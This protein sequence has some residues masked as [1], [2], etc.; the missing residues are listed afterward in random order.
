MKNS[1]ILLA[2]GVGK[3]LGNKVPKQFVKFGNTSLIEYFLAHLSKSIFYNII[4]AVSDEN[5]KKYLNSLK[6]QFPQHNFVFALA[7]KSRQ[8]SSKNALK[9]LKKNNPTNVLIHDSARPIISN[10]LILK[11]IKSLEKNTAVI[12]FVYH[13]N[14]IKIKSQKNLVLRN[15]QILHIQ[16][17]QGFKFKDIL[18]AHYKT[19]LFNSKDDST[20]I[21]ENGKKIKYIKGEVSNL[22]IT[23]KDDI[24][25]F[26]KIKIKEY[27]SGIGYDIHK[28][29]FQSNKK[30]VLCG[31]RINHPPLIGHSDADV[32]FHA[33]CDSILGALSMKDIGHFFSNK[34]LKWK[35]AN[36]K[37][38]IEFCARHLKEKHFRILNLDINFICERPNIS[39]I[40]N[41]MKKNLSLLLNISLKQ[42]SI[43]ATTNEK[44]S[45]IG[46]GEGIAAESIVQIVN[47]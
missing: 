33:I 15:N 41:K 3:R 37:K 21:E 30:L 31:I 17:P 32:G 8:Q 6:K 10:K 45:F 12:P 16:T 9:K 26:N 7:G 44:I 1:L 18:K 22:K 43:K 5:R 13:F 14:L 20:L 46:K 29:D 40:S 25:F 36:S 47:D 34:D 19:A 28:I 27:R 23:T 35:N 38:F 39:K 2:G 4:I 42:I 11:I 24:K